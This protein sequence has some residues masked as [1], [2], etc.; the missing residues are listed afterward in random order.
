MIS[1]NFIRAA[2]LVNKSSEANQKLQFN[3]AKQLC[4]KALSLAPELAEAWYNLGIAHGGL[5]NKKQA[6]DSQKK[7]LVLTIENAVA[8]NDISLELYHLGAE[9]IAEEGFKRAIVLSPQFA[10]PY[11]NLGIIYRKH[12][13]LDEAESSYRSA[14][15]LEPALAPIYLNL[16]GV[17]IAKEAFD[18]AIVFC[19]KAIEIDPGLSAAYSNLGSALLGLKQFEEAESVCRKAIEI[20]P[21]SAETYSNLGNLFAQQGHFD[22]AIRITQKAIELDPQDFDSRANLGYYQL[23]VEDYARGWENHEYRWEMEGQGKKIKRP[24]TSLQQWRGE[25]IQ[26]DASIVIYSEQGFGDSLHF[27]RYLPML[28]DYFN[29]VAFVCP[30]PVKQV[31]E[32]SLDD[33]IELLNKRSNKNFDRYQW[34]C[35][36]ISLPLAFSTTGRT[37]PSKTLYLKADQSQVKIWFDR[38]STIKL[39]KI[40]LVWQGSET[41]RGNTWRSIPLDQFIPILEIETLQFISLQ[42][43]VKKASISSLPEKIN[44]L[45]PMNK[46]SNFADTA[47]IIANL[48]LVVSVDT[49]VAHLAGA[50]GKPIWLLNRA[51]SEWRWGWKK[52]I[53]PWYPSMK[54]FNQNTFGNWTGVMQ[55]ISDTLKEKFNT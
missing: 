37:I 7:A 19:Q 54:I 4:K 52:K 2:S 33:R 36:L 30:E 28:F 11:S 31:L 50:M 42:K 44:L 17:L 41:M 49:S 16:G 3:R 22:E 5:S 15:A 39:P 27:C 20:D 12:G 18:E 46:V 29:S 8:Q 13:K 24:K 25:I 1:D 47:A 10:Q 32:Q 14:L 26:Q 51:S 6:V 23:F 45:N 43:G 9:N 34:Y 38:L 48:D 40:G 21:F 55:E 53:S 35:P